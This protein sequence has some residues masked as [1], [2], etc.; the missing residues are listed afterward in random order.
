M[1]MVTINQFRPFAVIKSAIS[2][3]AFISV[4]HQMLEQCT[5]RKDYKQTKGSYTTQNPKTVVHKC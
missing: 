3:H 1:K 2:L 4:Q 5:L